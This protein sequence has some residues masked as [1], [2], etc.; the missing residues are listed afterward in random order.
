MWVL[1]GKLCGFRGE[2]MWVAFLEARREAGFRGRF[3]LKRLKRLKRLKQI[4]ADYE[5]AALL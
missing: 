5:A 2:V 4:A 1:G 3:F